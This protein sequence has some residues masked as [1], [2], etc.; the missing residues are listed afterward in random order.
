MMATKEPLEGLGLLVLK[1][2]P[3]VTRDY[4]SFKYFST[5]SLYEHQFKQFYQAV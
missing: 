1:I 2:K 4:F 3:E 5:I